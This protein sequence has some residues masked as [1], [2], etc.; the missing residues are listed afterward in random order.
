MVK[1]SALTQSLISNE[2]NS[3]HTQSSIKMENK[4]SKMREIYQGNSLS[5]VIFS[6]TLDTLTKLLKHQDIDYSIGKPEAAIKNTSHLLFI[7]DDLKLWRKYP[8]TDYMN[9]IH[10]ESGLDKSA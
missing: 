3:D 9:Y 7:D 2:S 10:M 1:N 4:P 6:L 5:T 8:E